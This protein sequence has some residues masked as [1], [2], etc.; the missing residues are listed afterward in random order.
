MNP[1]RV[2][3]DRGLKE[4]GVVLRPI[5]SRSVLGYLA[6]AQLPQVES[7]RRKALHK[8]IRNI[9]HLSG[10]RIIANEERGDRTG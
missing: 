10:Q 5:H 7:H 2:P 4:P 9:T 6:R 3:S 8:M 1:R